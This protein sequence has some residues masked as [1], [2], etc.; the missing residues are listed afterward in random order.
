MEFGAA[1]SG[2]TGLVLSEAQTDKLDRQRLKFG[3][4]GVDVRLQVDDGNGRAHEV[5]RTPPAHQIWLRLGTVPI[6][7]ELRVPRLKEWQAISRRPQ[8]HKQQLAAVS[9]D[10]EL[11][12]AKERIGVRLVSCGGDDTA[13]HSEVQPMGSTGQ[14]IHRLPEQGRRGFAIPASDWRGLH[15]LV[16]RRGRRQRSLQPARCQAVSRRVAHADA[17]YTTTANATNAGTRGAG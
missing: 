10:L 2:L 1:T 7:V 8:W 14:G 3:R 6:A 5:I 13:E 15:V 9:G 12:I 11:K 16:R 4:V 17:R